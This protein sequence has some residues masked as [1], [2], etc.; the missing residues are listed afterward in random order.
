MVEAAKEIAFE[1]AFVGEMK[2][3][4]NCCLVHKVEMDQVATIDVICRNML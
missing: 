3:P 2:K 4:R 1:N